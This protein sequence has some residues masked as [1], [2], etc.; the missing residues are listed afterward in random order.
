MIGNIL[1]EMEKYEKFVLLE[2]KEEWRTLNL[3]W[4]VREW[5]I[6]IMKCWSRL[7]HFITKYKDQVQNLKPTKKWPQLKI[8]CEIIMFGARRVEESRS[9]HYKCQWTVIN[10]SSAKT[11][12][13]QRGEKQYIWLQ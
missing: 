11:D 9:E 2:Q 8:F 7:Y 3:D 4:I 1:K 6:S 13:R 10:P 5:H 12:S